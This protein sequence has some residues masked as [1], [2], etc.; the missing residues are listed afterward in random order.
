[1]VKVVALKKC[2]DSE[3]VVVGEDRHD[4]RAHDFS[5]AQPCHG[6]AT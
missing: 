2:A 5:D 1:V 4:L 3:K 6:G